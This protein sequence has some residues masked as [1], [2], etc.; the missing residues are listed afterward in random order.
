[1]VRR[2]FIIENLTRER[3]IEGLL[4]IEKYE[5]LLNDL[6]DDVSWQIP[7]YTLSIEE[8]KNA[9]TEQLRLLESDLL[10]K[11]YQITDGDTEFIK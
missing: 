4:L 6:I 7:R 3:C 10:F 11:L 5:E 9:L 2:G 1:M 8:V